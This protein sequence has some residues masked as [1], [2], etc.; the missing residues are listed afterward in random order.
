[1]AGT[2]FDSSTNM[3]RVPQ[4]SLGTTRLSNVGFVT[5]PTGVFEQ[6]MSGMMAAPVIG[7]L[8]GNVLRHLCF[9]VDYQ[10]GEMHVRCERA[11]CGHD[12]NVLGLTLEMHNGRC[13]V[14]AVSGAAHEYTRT[15][16]RPGDE[17][18]AVAGH[19]LNPEDLTGAVDC[20]RGAPG[21]W[22]EVQIARNAAAHDLRL[23]VVPLLG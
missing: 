9:S 14:G 16:V 21:S 17:V 2:S 20:L 13:F 18:A 8:A 3:I 1:M 7:A 22:L 5:R 19:R 12:L 15:E 11:E 10:N 6:Y 23:P 4:V